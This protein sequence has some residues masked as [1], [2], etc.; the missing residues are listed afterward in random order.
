MSNNKKG[1]VSFVIPAKDE[2]A[3]IVPL[4]EGIAAQMRR[5]SM[6]FE[7][8]FV[9]DGSVDTTWQEMEKLAQKETN[10]RALQFRSNVGKARALAVGFRICRGDPVFTMDA[11][12]Q[13]DPEEIPKFI[14]KLEEGYDVVSGYK[15]KRHD[16]WHKVIPSRVF[17]RMINF[18][19]KTDLHDHNCGFKCYR[20]EVI[21]QLTPYGEMHRMLVSLAN[22][23]G[24]NVG[25]V[26]VK[27]H[28]RKF[29]KSK[30]GIKRFIRGFM[31]LITVGFLGHYS[32]RPMHI[33][34]IT[35]ILLG[36]LTAI[37]GVAGIGLFAADPL[38]GATAWIVAALCALTTLPVL[39]CGLLA[40][41]IISGRLAYNRR[42]PI[43]RDTDAYFK[44]AI[45]HYEPVENTPELPELTQKHEPVLKPPQGLDW[46]ELLIVDDSMLIREF[47]KGVLQNS[48]LRPVEAADGIEALEKVN[49]H[50]AVVILDIRM[51]RLGGE[52]VLKKIKQDTPAIQVIV[53]SGMSDVTN[54]VSFLKKGAFDYLTKPIRPELLIETTEKAFTQFKEQ[55]VVKHPA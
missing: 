4:F 30:Y 41:L 46:Y 10:V 47:V 53:V 3:T 44:R 38:L 40:E 24:Y 26:E 42:P 55:S 36:I 45:P 6:D 49:P 7:V 8:I 16:P 52:E 9:D 54:I 35:V 2:A 39:A 13:D 28:P 25:E 48:G 23:E 11:D 37:F 34:G 32:E 1:C 20:K 43:I 51:P 19:A 22:F 29:G 18:V 27:H 14:E 31:D 17:N 12:L 21:D 50:T 33:A 5:I 15:K